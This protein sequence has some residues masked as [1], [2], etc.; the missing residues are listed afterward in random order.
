MNERD[1]GTTCVRA[2]TCASAWTA[3]SCPL[4]FLT[5]AR[6]VRPQVEREFA[7]AAPTLRVGCYYGGTPVGPQLRELRNGVEVVVGTPGRIIDLIDQDALDLSQVRR[8]G[9]LWRVVCCGVW[10]GRGGGGRGTGGLSSHTQ[11]GG[12]STE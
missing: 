11:E 3:K 5:P 1:C 6:P 10:C 8:A 12:G 9:V 4:L 2:C 7:S